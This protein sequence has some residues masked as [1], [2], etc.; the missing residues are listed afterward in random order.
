MEKVLEI[1][2]QLKSTTRT[3]EKLEI[4][5]TNKDNELLKKVLENTYNP[6]KNYGVSEKN[7]QKLLSSDIKRYKPAWPDGFEMLFALSRTS[8][9]D[10]LRGMIIQ[11]LENQDEEFKELWI[12]ILTKDLKIGMNVKSIN[13]AFKDL[14]PLS[15]SGF[16]VRC[17]LASK[18]NP[19]SIQNKTMY[20]TEKLDGIRCWAKYEDN[21]VT[22]YT[23]QGKSIIGCIDIELSIKDLATTNNLKNFI[24]D[25]E[26]LAT[27]CSYKDVYKETTK[28]LKNKKEIKDGLYYNVFDIISL[29]EAIEGIG[30]K[31]YSERREIL[32]SF[33]D[34]EYVKALPLLYKGN[35]MTD[36]TSILDEYRDRG[37]EGLMIN[38]DEPYEFKRS[39]AIL[40]LKIMQS[41]DLKVIGFE[42]GQGSFVGMLGAVLLEYKDNIVKCGSGWSLEE[43][44]EVWN[45]QSKYINKILEINYFEETYD[46]KTKLPSLR[47][48]VKKTWRNDK[49]EPSYN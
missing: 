19:K 23:R 17:M 13:K 24:L 43:R 42:Q 6:N 18:F 10:Y 4:L 9:N 26:I 48:P 31:K 14:I 37:A 1:L 7:L 15:E 5:K 3:N 20:V 39:S 22:L 36:I 11:F 46:S 45:N 44:Q 2:N 28:R 8:I 40:K 27:N 38:L 47:F 33:K 34:N 49:T 25:G 32:D 21:E 30:S 35:D 12:G 41:C 29:T 16:P